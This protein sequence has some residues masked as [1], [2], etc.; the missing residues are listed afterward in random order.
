MGRYRNDMDDERDN[1]PR[2]ERFRREGLGNYEEPYGGGRQFDTERRPEFGT[3]RYGERANYQNDEPRYSQSRERWD[4]NERYRDEGQRSSL[5]NL[6]GDQGL[7]RS[8]ERYS[9]DRS[10]LRCRDIMTKDLAV[11]TRNTALTQVA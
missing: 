11:A 4:E 9:S 8:R 5:Y 1:Y 10:R 7:Q 2:E 6:R 3:G